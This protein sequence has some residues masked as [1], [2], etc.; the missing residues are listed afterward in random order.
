MV[1]V[2]CGIRCMA[3]FFTELKHRHLN[4]VSAAAIV[5]AALLCQELA[6]A[7]NAAGQPAPPLTSDAGFA[8]VFGARWE[9]ISFTTMQGE[10]DA[11]GWGTVEFARARAPKPGGV[12][13]GG[14]C[15]E[16]FG[17][18]A[19]TANNGIEVKLNETT[20]LACPGGRK[21]RLFG[22]VNTAT[23]YSLKDGDLFLEVEGGARFCR[24]VLRLGDACERLFRDAGTL[25]FRHCSDVQLRANPR[26]GTCSTGGP[27]G[28]LR[29]R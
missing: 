29:G 16:S 20:L 27:I 15:N 10:E 24:D 17:F 8:P 21:D 11:R 28:T 4:S 14:D 1:W 19:L 26:Q 18:Y 23:S 5:I 25:R 13:V 22:L 2:A 3:K 9:A 7:A 12:L 6:P